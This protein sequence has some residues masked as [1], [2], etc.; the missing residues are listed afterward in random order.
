MEF[1]QVYDEHVAFVW[2]DRSGGSVCPNRPSTTRCRTFSSWFSADS[3]ISSK[4]PS[5]RPGSSGFACAWPRT[6]AGA[7]TSASE[8]LDD[9]NLDVQA[10]SRDDAA[11]MA[12][13][14]EDPRD[15]S[16]RRWPSSIST[17]ARCSFSSSSRT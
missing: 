14:Q 13:R 17:N 4:E 10:D 8:V 1:K 3:P 15:S 12:E 6:T 2:E 16:M 9:S 11:A 7:P 5:C